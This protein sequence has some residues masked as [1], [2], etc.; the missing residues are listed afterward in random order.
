MA[1]LIAFAV[2]AGAF[3]A[4]FVFYLRRDQVV[5]DVLQQTGGVTLPSL[6]G[7]LLT[8]FSAGLSEHVEFVTLGYALLA[9][10]L[11]WRRPRAWLLP[12]VRLAADAAARI[13]Y[14]L[15]WLKLR[16]PRRGWPAPER[17][18]LW[19]FVH[20][21]CLS[22]ALSIGLTAAGALLYTALLVLLL[23]GL[24]WL[25]LTGLVPLD[26]FQPGELVAVSLLGLYGIVFEATELWEVFTRR[27]RRW[28]ETRLAFLEERWLY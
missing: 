19:R 11:A 25:Q 14:A 28:Y 18:F 27:L 3:V 13:G 1:Y 5:A 15:G 4:S 22:V 7:P 24:R 23:R 20:Y 10:G 12:P 2:R 17:V 26:R 8:R 16:R 21:F 6:A 9:F